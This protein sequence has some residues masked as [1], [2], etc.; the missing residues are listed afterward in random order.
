[1]P[2][3]CGAAGGANGNAGTR[4]QPGHP[5]YSGFGADGCVDW[6]GV[7]LVEAFLVTSPDTGRA[8]A[9]PY[10]YCLLRLVK[11][12]AERTKRSVVFLRF[13]RTLIDI[14]IR[15]ADGAEPSTALGV[16]R[17]HR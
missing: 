17:L 14:P 9:C 13:A 4:R 6:S 2:D 1:M 15:A 10:R 16:Q 7:F 12:I 5:A 3:R 8:L 11:Q